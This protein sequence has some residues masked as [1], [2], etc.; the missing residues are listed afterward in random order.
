MCKVKA[1]EG[2]PKIHK[3]RAHSP[4]P[5]VRLDRYDKELNQKLQQLNQMLLNVDENR[6]T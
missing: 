3:N 2:K 4:S 5:E 6:L 1:K